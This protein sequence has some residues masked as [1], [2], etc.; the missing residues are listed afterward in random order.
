M[1]QPEQTD[2]N[3]LLPGHSPVPGIDRRPE[4][5]KERNRMRCFIVDVTMEGMSQEEKE[6]RA[7]GAVSERLYYAP[8]Y[9]LISLYERAG[10]EWSEEMKNKYR[11]TT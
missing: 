11:R 8:D 7:R 4:W 3:K 2:H 9:E 1:A 10:G 6:R 5:K